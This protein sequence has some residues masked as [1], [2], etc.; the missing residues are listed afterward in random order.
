MHFTVRIG[1]F[2]KATVSRIA[3]ECFPS[4]AGYLLENAGANQRFSLVG[5]SHRPPLRHSVRSAARADPSHEAAVLCLSEHQLRAPNVKLH[6]CRAVPHL[7]HAIMLGP[8]SPASVARPALLGQG[9]SVANL[10]KHSTCDFVGAAPSGVQY[11]PDPL[12][13]RTSARVRLQHPKGHLG[14]S[15]LLK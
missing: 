6:G 12:V 5:R 7:Q 9:C 1:E 2:P 10:G 13:E 15:L 8:A 14:E 11:K 3:V 4:A